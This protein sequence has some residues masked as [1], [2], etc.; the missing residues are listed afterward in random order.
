VG[1][2]KKHHKR[3]KQN[4]PKK[5]GFGIPTM[6]DYKMND[7]NYGYLGWGNSKKSKRSKSSN[8]IYE[9][10]FE[11]SSNLRRPTQKERRMIKKKY[12]KG[13]II[14]VDSNM[15]PMISLDTGF[16]GR[17]GTGIGNIGIQTPGDFNYNSKRSRSSN[18]SRSSGRSKKSSYTG[19]SVKANLGDSGFGFEQND[20]DPNR[21]ISKKGL[22]QTKLKTPMGTRVTT[23]I[24]V[25]DEEGNPLKNERGGQVKETVTSYENVPQGVSAISGGLKTVGSKIKKEYDA[26]KQKR[27][28][29][30]L[31]DKAFR[32]ELAKRGAR[33]NRADQ[34]RYCISISDPEN[35]GRARTVCYGTREEAESAINR[36]E[37]EGLQA[38]KI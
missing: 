1:K 7:S 22:K 32:A 13:R 35:T 8:S 16:G 30:E 24:P 37:A 3:R 25:S 34:E 27:I 2:R 28:E 21:E 15:N 17:T 31:A 38:H 33:A 4:K 36:A 20:L 14:G 9:P 6:S 29:R 23:E 5:Q 12:P 10:D 11:T 26:Q 18:S 19:K